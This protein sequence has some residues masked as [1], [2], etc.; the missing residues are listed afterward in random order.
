MEEIKIQINSYK[1]L[2]RLIGD[3]HD[4]ELTIKNSIINKFAGSYLKSIENSPI[5]EKIVKMKSEDYFGMFEWVNT[6]VGYKVLKLTPAMEKVIKER[7][8]QEFSQLLD[9]KIKSIK[10]DAFQLIDKRLTFLTDS[11]ARK[12]KEELQ[13][14]RDEGFLI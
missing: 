4:L 10:E 1:A 14:K 2:Q 3:D 5:L 6:E 13:K 9:E 7:V 11:V 8:E 12:M